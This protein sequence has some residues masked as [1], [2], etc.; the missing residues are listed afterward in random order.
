[1]EEMLHHCRAVRRGAPETFVIGDM[2]FGSYQVSSAEAVRNAVRF[3]KEGGC[4]AVKLEG[5]QRLWPTI[6][7]IVDAGILVM[8]HVGLT[9][10]SSASLG[11][12]RAQ[13]RSA[14]AAKAIILDALAVESAKAFSVVLEAVPAEVAGEITARLRIPT[15]G[16][17]AGSGCDGQVLVET[18][19]LGIYPDHKDARFVKRYAEVGTSMLEAF[20][21]Y[22]SDV[23]AKRFPAE[24]HSYHMADGEEAALRLELAEIETMQHGTRVPRLQDGVGENVG[25]K[26]GA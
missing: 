20:S 8:G 7:A 10:Q 24:E 1:M 16:I 22:A 15:L 3:V 13:G 18:D 12:L 19:L 11:G 14:E 4:D 17:G 26:P 23:R 5:G 21:A 2:P 6:A 9:P 25:A